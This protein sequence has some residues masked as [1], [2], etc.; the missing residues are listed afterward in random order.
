MGCHGIQWGDMRYGEVSGRVQI[1]VIITKKYA[2]H[3]IFDTSLFKCAYIHCK[4][5]RGIIRIITV[6]SC[7][8]I[9]K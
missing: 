3:Y 9:L 8:F 4:D 2:K 5:I 7:S 6:Y 1:I